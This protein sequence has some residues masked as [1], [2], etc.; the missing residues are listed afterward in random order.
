MTNNPILVSTSCAICGTSVNSTE[1]YAAN[2]SLRDLN[3]EIFSARRIPDK[4]HYRIVR[5]QSCGLVRSDPVIDQETLTGLYTKSTQT[6]DDEVP[7][8]MESYARYLEKTIR[9]LNGAG[10]AELRKRSLLEIGCGNGFFLEKALDYGFENVAG[11]EPSQQ[12]V[13][14]SSP[15][16]RH[17]II[18]DILRPGLLQPEQFDII[19][20]FQVF[21]HIAAPGIFLDECQKA[22][23]QG[24]VILCLNHDVAALSARLLGERS[25]IIDIEHTFLYSKSTIRKVFEDSG[26][27]VLEVGSAVNTYSFNYLIQ[28]VPLPKGLKESLLSIFR[29]HSFGRI[30]FSVRLGN[31]FLIAQKL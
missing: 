8:L 4:I 18:L 24:G 17:K 22:L 21:D 31:L 2:F 3:P 7:N 6:Y 30:K 10:S 28:L 13:E 20:M 1:L 27:K 25:P 19:C 14:K 26:F 16:L 12:A 23:K 15:R 29:S 11:I 9:Y 5:C